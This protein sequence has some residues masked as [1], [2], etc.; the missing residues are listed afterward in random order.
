MRAIKFRAWSN[1]LKHMFYPEDNANEPNL[2]NLRPCVV[3]GTLIS[4]TDYELMQYT[5]LKDKNINEIYEGDIIQC[6]MSFEGGTLPHMGEIV[7]DE[8]FGSF[9]TKNK[10][11]VT[12][13]C[14]HCLHTIEVIGNI[15]ENKEL[16]K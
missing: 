16:L 6:S 5:G 7:Y 14:N 1:S 4:K 15:F 11:G 3:G 2:W 10:A 8:T 9:G 13:L 12:L